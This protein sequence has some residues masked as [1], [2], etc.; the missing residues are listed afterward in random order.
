MQLKEIRDLVIAA[1]VL[2]FVFVYRGFDNLDATLALLPFG[3]IA[4]SLSF[5]LHEMS[6]RYF[7]KKYGQFA[8]FRLWPIGLLIATA[9]AIGTN[10]M[11]IFAAPGAVVIFQK[12]DLWGNV[13]TLT[14]KQ[15]GIISIS[16]SAMNMLLALGFAIAA[17]VTNIPLLF[18]GT[19]INIWLALF[20]MIPFG[21]LDGNKVLYWN[22]KIWAVFFALC[23]V[24][25]VLAIIFLGVF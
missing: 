15:L 10:G 17:V 2:A 19:F 16:G 18:T 5:I 23:I 9:L 13:K 4:V 3:L 22:K 6:H 25:F 21:P 11:F 14:K 24:S 20:N 8:E 1:I 12:A 7:A